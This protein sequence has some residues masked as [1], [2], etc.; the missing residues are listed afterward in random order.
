MAGVPGTFNVAG[1]GVLMLSQAIRRLGRP[2]L[3]VPGMMLGP[4]GAYLPQLRAAELSSE[5]VAFLTWGRGVDTRAAGERLGFRTSHTT[6]ETFEAF[7]ATQRPG[8]VNPAR[9]ARI[10][11]QTRW[12]ADQVTSR[13]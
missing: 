12:L 11:A 10:E 6:P 1:D 7:A 13:A 2:A 8:P 9:I 3:P 4:A 5:Q